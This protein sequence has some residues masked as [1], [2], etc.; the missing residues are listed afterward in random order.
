MGQELP[1]QCSLCQLPLSEP[2]QNT[3]PTW[4]YGLFNLQVFDVVFH[5]LPMAFPYLLETIVDLLHV[6]KTPDCMWPGIFD[7]SFLCPN[8]N[9]CTVMQGLDSGEVL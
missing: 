9:S 8:L 2:A 4:T 5:C 1:P 3:F 7:I 6:S